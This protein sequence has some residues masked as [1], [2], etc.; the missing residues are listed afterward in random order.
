MLKLKKF[1][2]H[3]ITKKYLEWLKDEDL[4]KYTSINPKIKI[5]E[6]KK[7]IKKHQNNKTQQ[8]FRIVF[9]RKHIGN[10]RF[11]FFMIML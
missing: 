2:F 6:V 11:F 3:N 8:L 7:Y 10:L 5:S 1:Y 9:N 4:I